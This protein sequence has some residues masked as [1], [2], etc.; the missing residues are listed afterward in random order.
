MEL[1]GGYSNESWRVESS[2]GA[3][4]VRKYGRLHVTRAA[5]AFEHAV[6]TY[7]AARTPEVFPPLHDRMDATM[8]LDEGAYVAVFPYIAG[9]TGARDRPAGIR[10]AQALARLH[11]AAQGIHVSSGMRTSRFLGMLPWLRER[12]NR[13]AS[14]PLLARQLP[15]DALI[16]AVTAA[17]ARVAPVVER[18]PTLIV[19]GDINPSNVVHLGDTVRGIIDFDFAHETER[20][21]DIGVLVDEFAR[22]HDDGAL[23][24]AR[25]A[26]LIA[27][28]AQGAPLSDAERQV[29]PDAMIRR[30]ATL[31]WYVVTR[32]GERVPGDIGGAPRYAKRVLEIAAHAEKLRALV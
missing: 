14:D 26:P 30:A 29:V 27:A 2:R 12:F 15:W 21:Y 28:Y 7:L 22:K 23:I 8:I 1:T 4:V 13:F 9:E 31:V 25:V 5:I 32:H 19:H 17:A 3:F 18:L 10:V 11:R 20:V 6:M 16:A 24:Y